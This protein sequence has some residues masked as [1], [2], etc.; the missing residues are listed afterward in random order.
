MEMEQYN[1]RI[2][3]LCEK[4]KKMVKKKMDDQ[5]ILDLNKDGRVDKKDFEAF[6]NSSNIL[7]SVV[8]GV[9]VSAFLDTIGNW[10]ESGIWSWDLILICAKFDI[11]P[12]IIAFVKKL[13]DKSDFAKNSLIE[14]LKN[15]LQSKDL[16]NQLLQQKIDLQLMNTAEKKA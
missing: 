4:I 3:N 9:L 15:N 12:A 2:F 10:W 5:N 16:A 1:N 7:W 11:F 6:I 14:Q 13:F 8:V